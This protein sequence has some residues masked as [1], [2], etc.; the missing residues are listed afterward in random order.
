MVRSRNE[1]QLLQEAATVVKESTDWDAC[2][3]LITGPGNT[4]VLVASTLSPE[5]AGRFRL[6]PGRGTAS[7]AFSSS[8]PVI[9]R[10][11]LQSDPDYTVHPG[12]PEPPYDAAFGMAMNDRKGPVGVL[13]LRRLESWTPTDEELEYL[14]AVVNDVAFALEV[15]RGGYD[16][17]AIGD[18]LS[19]VSEVSR[20]IAASPYLEEIL[21]L[22]VNLTAQ[23][24][25]Y[26][27]VTVRLLDER[28][29]ELVLR[30]TQATNKAYQRKEA[31]K[32]GQSIAGRVIEN[33]KTMIVEDVQEDKD[34]IGHDL[35]REQGLKSMVCVPLLL[36][37]RA[38]GV[39][40]CYTDRI[41]KF[42][43][44]EIAALETLAEQAAI[45]IEHARLQVRN[46]LMQEMHHRVK[47]NLQQ[48]ASLLRL[49]KRQSYYKTLDEALE[50]SLSRILAIA[51][52]HDLLSREDLDH[53]S[54]MTIAKSLVQHQ[55]QSFMLPG[56]SISFTVTGED[57][58][59][60]TTQATQ[61][62]LIINELLLNAV[63]H[64]F[65]VTDVGEIIIKVNVSG[66]A[67]ALVVSNS[68][69]PLPD[70]FDQSKGRLGMQIMRSLSQALG[71]EFLL[72]MKDG[73]TVAELT[74]TRSTAE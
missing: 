51:A 32:L 61:V 21:Q 16:A 50:D 4:L 35:A 45:S 31:I 52:V 39:I 47:N 3:I 63:E 64:G 68:G 12:I 48:V 30:A 34:Y 10:S 71:G 8:E 37:G 20:S 25:R 11:G 18:K 29:Q 13:F 74:F 1:E 59:L 17:A 23:R 66:D 5:Y 15:F 2:D 6:G 7:R 40:T 62:A 19:V 26:K 24:F 57:G 41:R 9:V 73:L 27:V 49:Q 53:V 55:Q 60:N 58:F 70:D 42:R 22:L 67:V 38:V 56:K 72:S 43:A 36:H 44:A 65:K 69:D 46:T 14:K 28:R 33:K 54:I